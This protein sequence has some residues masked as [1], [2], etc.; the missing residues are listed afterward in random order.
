[1]AWQSRPSPHRWYIFALPTGTQSLRPLHA[2]GVDRNDID[3][4]GRTCAGGQRGGAAGEELAQLAA[5]SRGTNTALRQRFCAR[6]FT[7]SPDDAAV[8]PSAPSAP[9]AAEP[10]P[11]GSNGLAAGPMRTVGVHADGPADGQQPRAGPTVRLKSL[12]L[13]A[14]NDA[15]G[16]DA[17]NPN[18]SASRT[19]AAPAWRARL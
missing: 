14:E 11:N 6:S 1:V 15:D 5:G 7:A 17:N 13:N 10:K 19:D 12:S 16:A 18:Q 8:Q 2:D 9:S 4:S 3:S